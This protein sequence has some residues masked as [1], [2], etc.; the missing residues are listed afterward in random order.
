MHFP[1]LLTPLN[2][3]HPLS[4]LRLNSGTTSLTLPFS[5]ARAAALHAALADLL[6]TF[7]E[8]A[9]ATR[10][11][12]WPST[13]FRFAGEEGGGELAQF[14]AFCNPNAHSSPFDAKV[15]VTAKGRDGVAVSMEMPLTGLRSDLGSYGKE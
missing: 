13:D 15:L 2:P 6:A 10:P 14:E 1:T 5:P 11:Q 8:K 4:V 7:S 12:R 3:Q 9:A